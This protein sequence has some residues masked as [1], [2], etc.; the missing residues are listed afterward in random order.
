MVVL[1]TANIPEVEAI[2]ALWSEADAEPSITDDPSSLRRLIM[3]DPAAVIVA[4]EDGRIVGSV[5][6]GWDGWRGSI[7]RLAVAPTYRRK[8]LGSQLVAMAESRFSAV[9]A[10][11]LQAIIVGSDSQATAF[12]RTSDWEEQAQRLRFVKG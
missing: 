1:K 8:G 4:Q 7:Y 5:I 11:R 3:H 9:G 12:W 10:I 6:A 2:L